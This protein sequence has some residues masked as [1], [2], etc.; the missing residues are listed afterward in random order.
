MAGYGGHH[1]QAFGLNHANM[2]DMNNFDTTG[3]IGGIKMQ[4]FSGS[5]GV[6]PGMSMQSSS[7]STSIVDGKKVST[8]K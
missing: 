8:I 5:L 3:G 1:H 6:V 4:N 2:F 7:T